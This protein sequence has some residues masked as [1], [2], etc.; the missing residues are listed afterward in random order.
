MNMSRI[1]QLISNTDANIYEGYVDVIK[2]CLY[3]K[4]EQDYSAFEYS[5]LIAASKIFPYELREFAR[6]ISNP[7]NENL[8]STVSKMIHD[9]DFCNQVKEYFEKESCEYDVLK[10]VLHPLS[11]VIGLYLKETSLNFQK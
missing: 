9:E 11:T 6:I 8:K 3:G 5:C 1:D 7:S 2:G 4:P 10:K